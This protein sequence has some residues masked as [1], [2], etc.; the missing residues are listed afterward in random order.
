MSRLILALALSAAAFPQ[1]MA[2]GAPRLEFKAPALG[3][4]AEIRIESTFELDVKSFSAQEPEAA[5]SKQLSFV[6]TQEFSQVAQ[7]VQNGSVKA[8]RITCSTAKLQRSGTNLPPVTETS[9]RARKIFV[10]P[11]RQPD[12]P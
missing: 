3:D 2:P 4:R 6:R 7:E 12:P 1:D 8:H 10:A 11:P 9:V 5:V